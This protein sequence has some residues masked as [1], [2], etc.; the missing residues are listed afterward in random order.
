MVILSSNILKL[1]SQYKVALKDPVKKNRVDHI[2]LRLGRRLKARRVLL[3][4]SGQDLGEATNISSKQIANYEK[5]IDRITSARLY[6]FSCLL[7]VPILY[8]FGSDE[9][10]DNLLGFAE[11]VTPELEQVAEIPKELVNL[12]N[13]FCKIKGTI[14]RKKTLGLIREFD[15]NSS[16]HP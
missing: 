5:G 4:M 8:F 6:A 3:G 10:S 16:K 2:D 1:T 9:E 11:N 14:L 13:S 15:I 7:R 12:I